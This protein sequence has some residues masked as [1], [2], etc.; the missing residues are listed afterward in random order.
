MS[1]R[2]F[3]VWLKTSLWLRNR[4]KKGRRR[5]NLTKLSRRTS[6]S[7]L[8]L[9]LRK[10]LQRRKRKR[11]AK[12]IVGTQLKKEVKLGPRARLKKDRPK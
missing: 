9:L 7:P 11:R 5:S 1:K 3:Q 8:N 2:Q 12:R 4:R 6:T 10:K